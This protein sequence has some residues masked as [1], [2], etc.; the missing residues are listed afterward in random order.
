MI[1]TAYCSPVWRAV[2]HSQSILSGHRARLLG[3][4]RSGVGPETEICRA[5]C[6][7]ESSGLVPLP[8]G[9]GCQDTPPG[10]G[11]PVGD[12]Q[13]CLVAFLFIQK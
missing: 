1:N 3:L 11:L 6:R 12:E 8:S 9:R 4:P 7:D 2:R 5:C 10:S 13:P